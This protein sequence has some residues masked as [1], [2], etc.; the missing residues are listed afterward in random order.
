MDYQYIPSISQIDD[1]YI[2]Y[3]ALEKDN[4]GLLCD[5]NDVFW[6]DFAT[7]KTSTDFSSATK[8]RYDQALSLKDRY[9][10]LP[11][12][13][14]DAHKRPLLLCMSNLN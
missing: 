11:F 2:K 12:N 7:G 6:L 5:G 4:L 1:P 10:L 3:V 9:I 8:L 13:I 14:A